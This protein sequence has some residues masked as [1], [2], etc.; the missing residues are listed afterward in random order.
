ML[1]KIKTILCTTIILLLVIPAIS[2]AEMKST[3]GEKVSLRTGPG[4]QYSVKWELG[5]G[6]PVR[7]LSKKGKWTKVQDFENDKGWVNASM[8]NNEPHVIV[9]VNKGKNKKINI[10]SGPGTKYSVVGKAYYGVV[11]EKKEQKKGW[12]KVKHESGLEG[13]IE[14]TL[15]WG[16]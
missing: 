12:V 16:F 3:S 2:F 14:K 13:W 15:V 10:R 9:K 7:I 1:S 8:L 4:E 5:N 11:F 6:F